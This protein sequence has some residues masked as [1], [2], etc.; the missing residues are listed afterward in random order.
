[1]NKDSKIELL[2]PCGNYESAISAIKA[3]ADSIYVG[4]YRLFMVR[5]IKEAD[6]SVSRRDSNIGVYAGGYEKF[7][8]GEVVYFDPDGNGEKKFYVLKNSN[9]TD[10]TMTLILA[11][12]IDNV[13]VCFNS[14]KQ[15]TIPDVLLSTLKSKTD[16][17]ENEN[18]IT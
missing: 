16:T 15:S 11:N 3:G 1:M 6:G 12:N 7:L 10:E 5:N 2:S 18:N 9:S 13:G 17:S 8:Q 14:T 4:K